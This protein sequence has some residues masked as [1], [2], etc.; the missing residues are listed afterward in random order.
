VR[1]SE[2]QGSDFK[3]LP[4]MPI[5]LTIKQ[6]KEEI[7]KVDSEWKKALALMQEITPDE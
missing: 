1:F 4:D 6:A 7:K 2:V 5:H 3:H